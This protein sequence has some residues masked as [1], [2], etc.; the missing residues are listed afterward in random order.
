MLLPFCN[1]VKAQCTSN[2]TNTADEDIFNVTLGTLNNTSGCATTGGTGSIQNEYSNYAYAGFP[3]G[4]PTLNRGCTIPFSVQVGTCGG[5]YN[6]AVAIYIDWNNDADFVDAGENVYLS[7]TTT[8]GPHTETGNITIPATATLGNCKMRVVNSETTPGSIAPCGTYSWG[9]TED[10]FINIANGGGVAPY[11]SSSVTQLVTGSIS[12]CATLQQVICIPVVMGAGCTAGNLTQF[13]LGAGSST[14]LP[15]DVSKIHIFY[16]GTTNLYTA[17][18][19]FVVGGTT[20]AGASNTIN[21]SQAL[22]PNATNYFWVT[23]DMNNGSTIGDL[24]D[25]SCTQITI[26]G[27]SQ[28]PSL[29]S[30][31]GSGTIV[32]CPCSFSLG[33]DV[34]L[35]APFTYTLNGPAGFDT[36]TWTPGGSSTQNLVVS[37]VGTYTCSAT[38]ING[39][40][41]TNGNFSSGNTGFSSNYIPGPGGTWGPLSNPGTYSVTNNPNSAH[42]NFYSFGDHTTGTGNMLVCNGSAVANDVAWSQTITVTPN[43]FYNFSAWVAST[44]NTS[45]GSE[46]QLQF[47]INGSL[48]GP[49]YSA[50]LTGATWANFFVN[51][52]S[53][54]NTSAIIKIVDQNTSGGANDFALDDINFE[55]I[56]TYS[57]VIT[58]NSGSTATVSVPSNTTICNGGTMAASTFTSSTAGVTYTWSN[59]N[60]SIGLVANGT[61]NTPTFTAVNT[62]TAPVTAIITVTPSVGS[63]IGTPKSY[64][65]TINP[66]PVVTVNSPTTC[67]G[68]ATILTANG[69]TSYSWST[70][71]STQTISS[72]PLVQTVYTVT[73]TTAGCI[74]SNTSTVSVNSALS[75]IVNSATICSGTSTVLT[76]SGATN[77]TW[78]TG[79]STSTISVSPTTNTVYAVTGETSGCTGANTVAVTVNANPTVTVNSP[80]TCAGIATIL[81]AN[82]ATG[83]SWSTGAI[84]QSISVS[85]LTQTIY[86]VTGTTSG[87]TG[88]ITST[89]SVNA[90][91]SV[92]VNSPT[93]C[94]GTPTVLTASGATN[95]TWSTGATTS[96]ISISPTSTTSYSVI[97]ETSG[98]LGTQTVSINVTSN[99][100][101]LINSPTICAGSSTVLTASGATNYTWSTG[102]ATSTISVSPTG[103]T[104]YTLTGE[105]SGCTGNATTTVVVN[106]LP[107]IGVSNATV[108]AGSSAILTANGGTSY[109]WSPGLISGTSVT[110]TPGITTVYSVTGS[111]GFCANVGTGTVVVTPCS[112]PC[113]FTLANDVS[114]CTPLSYT[115]NGPVGFASYSWTPG[116]A[117]TQNLVVTTPGT[118]T[119]TAFMYSND[120]VVNGNF[121]AGNTG[122]STNYSLGAGGSFGPLTNPGTYATT[123]S[124][125]L[126]HTN[127]AAFGD[128]TTGTGSM[129]VCNGSTVANDIVWSQ[130]ITVTPNTNYNF[131]AWVASAWGPLTA[132]QEA[133]LQFS[134]NST[135]VGSVFNA[136][137]TAGSWSNFAV[138]WNSGASTSA[139]I[140][141]VDQNIVASGANDF[142]IDDIFFQQICSHSDEITIN[143]IATPTVTASAITSV[144]CSGSSTTLN[145]G[146]ASTYTWTSGVTNG[147]AF[148]PTTTATYT[149][150]GTSVAG[151]TN[152]AVQTITVNAVPTITVNNAT[153][154]SGTSTVLTASGTAASFTWMPGSI[155]TSTLNVSPLSTTIYT[156]TGTSNGCSNTN[157]ATVNINAVPTLTV[158]N[159][160][161]CSGN[162]VALTATPSVIGGTYAW[163]PGSQTTSII[164]VTPATTTSY[165]V[166]YSVN[167]C[168][169][170]ATS[171]VS[172]NNTPSVSVSSATVCQG[173]TAILIATPSAGGG[174]YSW[175]AGGQ[176][177]PSIS[178]TPTATTVY[179]V[180]YSLNGC[181][182]TATGT[183]IVN[184][185]PILLLSPSAS[186]VSSLETVNITASGGGTYN[187]STGETGTTISVNPQHTT[188]YCATVT[189]SAGCVND[190]CINIT[191]K[192][193][194]NL[195]IPNVFTPNEDGVNDVFY[196][197]GHN[198]ISYSLIIFNRWGEKLFSSD[199][200]LKGWDGSFGGKIVPDGVYVYVL[201]AKGADETIY[202]KAGHITLFK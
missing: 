113:T 64:T 16:T 63:C 66:N 67:A 133:Q 80:T 101:V 118:Y 182:T 15:A 72:A 21:G 77:Y 38:L 179:G 42:S 11:V 190:V 195:Y 3:G 150:T 114:L 135:L 44:E 61:G 95:Y 162:S 134:I 188:T 129:M 143:G 112:S 97:G 60:A 163:L 78:S 184:P 25:G 173:K 116:G 158:N 197:S 196:T 157:T 172:V 175:S 136:P 74:G 76:A 192:E 109:T 183:M 79:A 65:L 152:T 170:G 33:S 202:K 185:N 87:C 13:Q 126:V 51:W 200:I 144:I 137:L 160:T 81:T 53:G 34:T 2:A 177:I 138:N 29:T 156:V 54:S 147:A 178:E 155:T 120:L 75:I 194:S 70:G 149:V 48:I 45:A 169:V 52:N 174:T 100:T 122:F 142:A 107:V 130:T 57:D 139:V 47:S 198:I 43:T 71:A 151:C 26:G 166:T 37:S 5:N 161:I 105:T 125:N 187:W 167:G 58:I 132:G 94:S 31:A 111:D 12:Q 141:I 39:G 103:N 123:T 181:T 20:P 121:S 154:C 18:N 17:S 36:Y 165:S 86:T 4:V 1:S 193:E 49:V 146:G 22:V 8:S 35:C 140:T 92:A 23:Y 164:S 201:D 62:G 171:M 55:R 73:G 41:V 108:C 10:Y 199:D 128:H 24:V 27:V 59:T 89:V 99:P 46:A 85:P 191:V 91:L 115:I 50:P 93:I 104:I 159:P 56:C 124:P 98:C 82:G 131:S 180:L 176:T 19:E 32:T 40:L 96:T 117:T 186:T 102:A 30:P 127:F 119:C 145:A 189:T 28:V 83:Y 7:A 6:N 110:V 168:T 88:S 90:A 69:A 68:V 14:N 153:L 148:S 106:S 9:E 84:T